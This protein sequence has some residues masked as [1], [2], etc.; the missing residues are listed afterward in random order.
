LS[1]S[2]VPARN[3]KHIVLIVLTFVGKRHT[4]DLPKYSASKRDVIPSSS[5]DEDNRLWQLCHRH[6]SDWLVFGAV[7]LDLLCNTAVIVSPPSDVSSHAHDKNEAAASACFALYLR[8][9]LLQYSVTI[10]TVVTSFQQML[11]QTRIE[12]AIEMHTVPILA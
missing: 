8:Q 9:H 12:S 3:Q 7:E 4:F 1:S 11:H 10:A 6:T 5:F 2:Q